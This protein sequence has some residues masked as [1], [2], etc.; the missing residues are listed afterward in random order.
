MEERRMKHLIGSESYEVFHLLKTNQQHARSPKRQENRRL[1]F[2]FNCGRRHRTVADCERRKDS[3][4][5]HQISLGRPDPRLPPRQ[6]SA[7]DCGQQGWE[8]P[9]EGRDP[10]RSAGEPQLSLGVSHPLNRR[11]V[12]RV[13][14]A[15]SYNTERLSQQENQVFFQRAWV[16][17]L[18]SLPTIH[19]VSTSQGQQNL[20]LFPQNATAPAS[21]IAL[22]RSQPSLTD[23]LAASR[24]ERV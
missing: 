20:A 2:R 13:P 6:V 11:T 17:S 1:R 12:T 14:V 21:G 15:S 8:Q 19:A 16:E 4:A 24:L 10:R 3:H 9:S 5:R 22:S 23:T 18:R 7:I